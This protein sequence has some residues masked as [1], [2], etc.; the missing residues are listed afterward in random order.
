MLLFNVVCC[1]VVLGPVVGH[2]GMSGMLE[3]AELLLG[4]PTS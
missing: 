4:F 1:T 2:V 3:E